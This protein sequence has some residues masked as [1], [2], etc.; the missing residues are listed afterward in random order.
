MKIGLQTW[1]TEGDIRPFMALAAGLSIAGHEVTLAVTEIQNTDFSS[2][3][4]RLGFKI[5]HIGRI[6]MDDDQFKEL[7]DR[8]FN[9]WN[10]M[11]RGDVL[12]T[13]F[14]DPVLED[15]LEAAKRL[16]AEN[17]LVIGHFFVYPLKIAAIKEPCPFVMV[18]TTPLIPSRFVPPLGLPDLGRV[19]APFW[20]RL[21]D[22]S[23]NRAWKPAIDDMYRREGVPTEKSIFYGIWRSSLLNLVCTSPTLCPPPP[24]WKNVY[25]LCGF[26]NLPDRGEPWEMPESLRRFLENG[27]P[28]VYM[29][30]GSM[31]ASD[32]KPEKITRLLIDAAR[33]SGRRCIIQ[34]NWETLPDLPEHPDI[35]RITRA[36][37]QH[38]F[39]HCAAVVH[40]GGAGTTQSATVAGCPSVVVEHA[41]DQPLWGSLLQ[42]T[43]IAPP[44]L[45][46]RTVTA[47]KLIRA[48]NKALRSPTMTQKAQSIGNRM[49]QENGVARAVELIEAL[50]SDG[51]IPI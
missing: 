4:E 8:V 46:R 26:L 34:S 48:I 18:F 35:Y 14:L 21:F 20:W 39:P 51:S 15:M 6:D 36:P 3:G 5:R 12:V 16:C 22:F 29:T 23:L 40:H 31:L 2:Y 25:H 42:R 19:L 9:E 41:S 10:P 28:P 30:F 17:D 38:V 1:G 50:P 44:V 47:K 11:K 45:H 43:G 7:A 32:P 49:K 33:R 37:H 13:Y 27:T 24:D